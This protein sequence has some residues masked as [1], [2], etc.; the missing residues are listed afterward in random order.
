MDIQ[1]PRHIGNQ[2]EVPA[3]YLDK[4]AADR[5][6]RFD[7]LREQLTQADRVLWPLAHEAKALQTMAV[8]LGLEAA[9]SDERIMTGPVTT[10][11]L[12]VASTAVGLRATRDAIALAIAGQVIVGDSTHGDTITAEDRQLSAALAYDLDLMHRHTL[13]LGDRK[14]LEGP[15]YGFWPLIGRALFSAGSWAIRSPLVHK[16]IRYTFYLSAFGYVSDKLGLGNLFGQKTDEIREQIKL[17]ATRQG[18]L[19]E[20]ERTL[21]AEADLAK[22]NPS[23]TTRVADKLLS[24]L[25]VAGALYGGWWLW[26][27]SKKRNS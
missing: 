13:P 8:V 9:P 19:P 12:T 4:L 21:R 22:A 16:G 5:R 23:P 7:Y 20:L 14:P 3:A 17:E 27:S 24:G 25:M 1:L 11:F 15:P 26:Q 6:A 10:H 2:L 18:K